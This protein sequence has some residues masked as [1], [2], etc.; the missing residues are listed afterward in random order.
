MK[1]R[2]VTYLDDSHLSTSA[3]C[4]SASVQ[5]LMHQFS[6]FCE[7]SQKR[8]YMYY[9]ICGSNCH[10]IP[11]S[12]FLQNKQIKTVIIKYSHLPKIKSWVFIKA[13]DA[14]C[15]MAVVVVAVRKTTANY[16]RHNSWI[17]ILEGVSAN[18]N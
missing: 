8:G 9:R 17:R 12:P 13:Y 15:S 1:K 3:Q 5:E 4:H 16:L 18:M 11:K 7:A 6:N 2:H 14:I 10:Q